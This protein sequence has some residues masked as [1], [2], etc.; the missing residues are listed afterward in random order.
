MRL[1][2]ESNLDDQLRAFESVYASI[3]FEYF[4][5]DRGQGRHC[6]G[7]YWRSVAPAHRT[8]CAL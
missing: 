3:P 7:K 2:F 6:R 5:C 8:D 4:L 1:H